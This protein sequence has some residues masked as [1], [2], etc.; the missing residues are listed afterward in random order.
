[1]ISTSRILAIPAR[2][3]YSKRM[4]RQRYMEATHHFGEDNIIIATRTK[5]AVASRDGELEKRPS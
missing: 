5:V 4:L 2:E 3:V 1:M